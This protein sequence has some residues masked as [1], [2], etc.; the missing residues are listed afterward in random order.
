MRPSSCMTALPIMLPTLA[1]FRTYTVRSRRGELPVRVV[2]RQS[3][4]FLD[5][6]TLSPHTNSFVAR[7]THLSRSGHSHAPRAGWQPR[8]SR[9]ETGPPSRSANNL[10][11]CV[12]NRYRIRRATRPARVALAHAHATSNASSNA[13]RRENTG[14]RDCPIR[15][16]K[17][18]VAAP[19]WPARRTAADA[20]WCP[21]R[22]N[23]VSASCSHAAIEC[24]ELAHEPRLLCCD[25]SRRSASLCTR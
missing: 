15:V 12:E 8:R 23:S 4:R 5:R 13:S 1:H 18:F 6:C 7:A 24:A 16:I 9:Y 20:R 25:S 10:K 14:V 2:V 17:A 11:P 19:E 3:G 22:Q 21:A